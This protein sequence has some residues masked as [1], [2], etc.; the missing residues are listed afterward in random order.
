LVF[1]CVPHGFLETAAMRLA[2][3]TLWGGDIFKV[4]ISRT[5]TYPNCQHAKEMEEKNWGETRSLWLL[6]AVA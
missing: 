6:I 1:V 2:H 3:S 4:F 5:F